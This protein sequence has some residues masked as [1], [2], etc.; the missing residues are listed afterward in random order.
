MVLDLEHNPLRPSKIRGEFWK[1]QISQWLAYL[2]GYSHGDWGTEGIMSGG[3]VMSHEYRLHANLSCSRISMISYEEDHKVTLLTKNSDETDQT[4]ETEQ[5]KWRVICTFANPR[6]G[7]ALLVLQ[8]N[9]RTGSGRE[10][11]CRWVAAI[12]ASQQ[13]H[14]NCRLF[15]STCYF[16]WL[17]FWI[18]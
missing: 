4:D 1:S 13:T 16:C 14:M 9:R 17:Y 11:F 12:P 2:S 10:E 6:P 7:L 8:R 5:R 3:Y 15:C 18:F